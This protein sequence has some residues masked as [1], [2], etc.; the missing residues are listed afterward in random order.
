LPL[1]D[2]SVDAAVCLAGLHH[3]PRRPAVFGEIHRVLRSDGR[4]AIAEIA[5]GSAVAEFFDNFV[6]AHNSLGH[7]GEFV[8]DAFVADLVDAGFHIASDQTVSYHWNFASREGMADFLRLSFGIDRA[9]PDQIV[10][11]VESAL[12]I[13]AMPNGAVAMRWSLRFMLAHRWSRSN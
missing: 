1:A 10:A 6:N 11:A 7:Q 4:L 13:D 9:T 8:D 5:K 3:E 2:A 12:G